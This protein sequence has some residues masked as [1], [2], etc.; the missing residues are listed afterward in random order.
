MLAI[1]KRGFSKYTI[2]YRANDEDEHFLIGENFIRFIDLKK[3]G[4]TLPHH[5]L[6]LQNVINIYYFIENCLYCNMKI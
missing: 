2:L 5:G 4:I 3:F 1:L 6:T